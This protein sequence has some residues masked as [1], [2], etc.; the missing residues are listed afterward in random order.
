MEKRIPNQQQRSYVQIGTNERG[1]IHDRSK[2]L[3][4]WAKSEV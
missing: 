2:L 3:L 4:S 1:V